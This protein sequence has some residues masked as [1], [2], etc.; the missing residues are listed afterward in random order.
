[1]TSPLRRGRC[2]SGP[3]IA[4]CLLLCAGFFLALH[5]LHRFGP[6]QRGC[7]ASQGPCSHRQV[8][9]PFSALPLPAFQHRHR[10][11]DCLQ[12]TSSHFLS[13]RSFC[14]VM[15]I[16]A[17]TLL[18][19]SAATVGPVLTAAMLFPGYPAAFTLTLLFHSFQGL[20]SCSSLILA[21][22]F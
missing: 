16:L 19:I 12:A 8:C 2:P 10:F 9:L 11:H 17:A 18:A 21:S 5:S 1:M 22:N 14:A 15:P 3:C 6:S 7:V 13:V 4:S 20:H